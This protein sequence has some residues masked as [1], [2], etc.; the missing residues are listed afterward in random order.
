MTPGKIE[1][2]TSPNPI[3]YAIIRSPGLAGRLL[4]PA[5]A[6]VFKTYAPSELNVA[7]MY[8]LPPTLKLEG[9]SNPGAR[10]RR[11]NVNALLAALQLVTVMETFP[12]V[13][14]S[15][16]CTLICPAERYQM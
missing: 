12:T 3:P 14:S 11:A 15:G 8:C 1:G 2:V 7:T 16:A 5:T 13:K 4:M 9:A 10:A 6:P